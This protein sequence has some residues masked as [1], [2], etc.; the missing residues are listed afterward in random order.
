MFDRFTERARRTMSLA[1]QEAL[2]FNHDY[3]GTEHLLLG[4]LAEGS[5]VAA[6][7]LT[8]LRIDL[9]EVRAEVEKIV[10]PGTRPVSLAQLPFTPRAKKV[11]E[12]SLEE[13][14]SL[15]HSYIG[16][17]HLLLGLLREKDSIAARVLV[18]LGTKLD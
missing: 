1:R 13:A 6:Q 16:T 4:L 10:R 7:A 5:G 14:Q 3:I 18:R 17:E 2:R 12:L 8:N 11:L 9:S 15:Q